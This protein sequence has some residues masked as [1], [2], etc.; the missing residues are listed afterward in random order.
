MTN[1]VRISDEAY[2]RLKQFCALKGYKMSKVVSDAVMKFLIWHEKG[3]GTESY[4]ESDFLKDIA[5]I[6]PTLK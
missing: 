4:T 1:K 3:Y 5:K 2:Q 6:K